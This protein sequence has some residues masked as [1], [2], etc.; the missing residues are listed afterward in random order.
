MT[1]STEQEAG[2]LR[3]ALELAEDGRG[4]VSPNPLVGAVIV[5]D[6]EVIGEG[7]HAEYGGLHAERAA[8]EDCRSRDE[9]PAGT[10]LYLTLEPCAH[11]GKQP[12]CTEAILEAGISRVVYASDDPT[13]KASGRGPGMLRDG[14]V[15]VELAGGAE[16]SAARLLN[17]AFRKRARTGRPLV[18]YKAAMSLDG[19]VASPT[20]DSRWISS[21]E[22]RELVHRWRSETDAVA[23]GIGTALADDP[24]LTARTDA[25]AKQPTRV[26]FDS[27]ARLPLTSAL[28]TSLD[29]APLIVVCAPEA[30]TSRRDG[31]EKAGVEVIVAPGRTPRARL[32]SALD[33]LGRREI[34]D[35][36]VEGG[37]TLA[38][39]MFD[40]GEIDGV[41]LFVAPVLV[42]AAQARAV[43]E[44]EGV[45]RIAEGVRP[46]ETRFEE[47]GED[48][49]VSARLREW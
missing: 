6:G 3:R 30:A 2:W 16:A 35:L 29:E 14:G 23:V 24:L 28:V 39:A 47:L 36:F 43:L 9:D 31:L 26:V 20:G 41:R 37:P 25:A 15:E 19:R 22:S 8:L 38:G 10:S 40:A 42:G 13:D 4:R 34:Q 11:T 44:G 46:L 7:F 27:Q 12:P 33:E 32:E 18:T 49:L 1:V 48:L 5:R 21:P 17:Q 45:A